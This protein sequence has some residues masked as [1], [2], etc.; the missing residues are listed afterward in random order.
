MQVGEAGDIGIKSLSVDGY[1]CNATI[2]SDGKGSRMV[3]SRCGSILDGEVC[4]LPG[5]QSHWPGRGICHAEG[6]VRHR[7]QARDVE[8]STAI[9]SDGEFSANCVIEHHHSKTPLCRIESE[10][11][12]RRQGREKHHQVWQSCIQ[13]SVSIRW[14]IIL[15]P[16]LVTACGAGGVMELRVVTP[17]DSTAAV[18]GFH[19]YQEISTGVNKGNVQGK[20]MPTSAIEGIGSLFHQS[21]CANKTIISRV[22][23][24]PEH[25]SELCFGGRRKVDLVGNFRIDAQRGRTPAQGVDYTIGSYLIGRVKP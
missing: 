22:C 3:T 11:R 19:A 21:S 13:E 20:G 23:T 12:I 17:S 25:P 14:A 7:T 4:S 5:C 24:I 2:I 18:V 9:I 1:I 15:L 6:A 16:V 10:D 8:R